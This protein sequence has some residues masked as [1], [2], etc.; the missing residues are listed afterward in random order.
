MKN[1]LFGFLLVALFS[2]AACEKEDN[3]YPQPIST[4]VVSSTLPVGTWRVTYYFDTDHEETASFNGYAFTFGGG[5][6]VTAVKA[7]TTVTGA[8]STGTD[9]SKTKLILAFS[10]PE[11]FAEISDDWHVVELTSTKIKLQDES[12]GNDGTDVLTFEKN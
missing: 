5:N 8:W 6:V 12:G 7:G 11:S 2:L 9:D 10:S 1:S 4:G 3:N